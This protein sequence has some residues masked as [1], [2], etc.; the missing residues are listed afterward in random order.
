MDLYRSTIDDP[1][2]GKFLLPSELA[3]NP[4]ICPCL[5]CTLKMMMDVI[6][7]ILTAE[8]IGAAAE[9]EP[10]PEPEAKPEKDVVEAEAEAEAEAETE[11][12]EAEVEDPVLAAEA[13]FAKEL[14]KSDAFC[15]LKMMHFA[16]K[17]MEFTLKMMDFILKVMDFIEERKI[18]LAVV[19]CI[20][21]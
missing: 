13:K 2:R 3:Q 16:L 17:M 1:D 7:M 9:P 18:K 21:N 6:R 20:H 10:E 4:S 12:V 8:S 19:R 14:G 15:S 5:D 11:A